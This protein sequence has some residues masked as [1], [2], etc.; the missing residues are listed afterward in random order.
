MI[1][2]CSCGYNVPPI[3][4]VLMT[5]LTVLDARLQRFMEDGGQGEDYQ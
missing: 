4:L 5:V 1:T 2:D 3:N